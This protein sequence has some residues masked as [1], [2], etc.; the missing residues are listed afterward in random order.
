MWHF[1]TLCTPPPC[2]TGPSPADTSTGVSTTTKLTWTAVTGATSYDVYFGTTSS[3][4]KKATVT[5]TSYS[6]G[7]LSK[8]TKYYWQIIPKNACGSAS[9]CSVWSFTTCALPGC[10]SNPSPANGATGV[11]TTPTLTWSA[12]SGATSYAVYFGT[13]ANPP[14]KTTVTG[15]SYTPSTLTKNKTYY[16]KIIPANGCGSATGCTTWSFKTS[17]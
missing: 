2:A 16:W 8:N 11:S 17:S 4:P 6:P 3:P 9:G 13:T 15:T 1:K 10:A 5:T 14:L 12:V 7:T